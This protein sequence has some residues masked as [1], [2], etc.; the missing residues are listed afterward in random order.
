M[1]VEEYINQFPLE[2]QE[3]LN[4]LRCLIKALL[5]E[6]KEIISYGIPTYDINGHVIHFAGYKNHIGMYPTSSGIEHFKDRLKAYKTSKGTIQIPKN[7]P[8]PIDL[9][10]EIILFRKEEDSRRN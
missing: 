8:L 4:E 6:A 9:I 3:K 2:I 7:V 10:K 1:T 5:P